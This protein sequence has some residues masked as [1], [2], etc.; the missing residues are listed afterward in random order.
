MSKNNKDT[1]LCL[2]Q[3]YAEKRNPNSQTP[4]SSNP[5]NLSFPARACYKERQDRSQVEDMNVLTVMWTFNFSE[6]SVRFLKQATNYFQLEI[7]WGKEIVKLGI[8]SSGVKL[9]WNQNSVHVGLICKVT[10]VV[11]PCIRNRKTQT[12]RQK[13]SREHVKQ[14]FID[15]LENAFSLQS[16][17]WYLQA[18]TLSKNSG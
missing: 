4:K 5:P 2:Q 9:G 12:W 8:T 16:S 11:L 10:L 3:I 13:A 15:F 7:F 6:F 1:P 18:V 17:S 14:P